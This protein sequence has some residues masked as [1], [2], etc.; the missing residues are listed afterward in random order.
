MIVTTLKK[1][2]YLDLAIQYMGNPAEAFSLAYQNK[3][4][5]TKDLQAGEEISIPK[6]DQKYQDVVNYFKATKAAPATA[7]PFP[8]VGMQE[9]V[10]YWYI[11]TDFIVT[12]K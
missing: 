9:G 12:E 2:N 4:S 10:G 7:Y 6:Y 5:L 1:Q 8:E 11:N 3:E